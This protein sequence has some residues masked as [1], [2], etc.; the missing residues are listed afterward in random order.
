MRT[1]TIVATADFR[2][3]VTGGIAMACG[4][5]TAYIPLGTKG[6]GNARISIG[7]DFAK[8][9]PDGKTCSKDGDGTIGLCEECATVIT[10]DRVT[11]VKENIG[12][13]E[14]ARPT[15]KHG[16]V[17]TMYRASAFLTRKGAA[18]MVAEERHDS[19]E[20]MA[21][22]HIEGGS[23]MLW[24]DTETEERKPFHKQAK[25]YDGKKV[26][27]LDAFVVLR[28]G[29]KIAISRSTDHGNHMLHEMLSVIVADDL[30]VKLVEATKSEV[31]KNEPAP[32][33][34][35]AEETAAPEVAEEAP[36]ELKEEEETEISFEE[37][38]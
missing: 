17:K 13:F 12:H 38:E 30:Q 28:K 11:M 10:R 25:I 31:P 35:E 36:V 21:L 8:G 1:N 34:E 3:I 19:G 20:V 32:A 33:E 5:R 26:V 37:K 18:L 29:D 27:G 15:A 24:V 22:F 23:P 2:F 9:L 16:S 6:V 4:E 7:T 14:Q